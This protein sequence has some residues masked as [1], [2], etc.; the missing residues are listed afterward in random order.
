MGVASTGKWKWTAEK[1]KEEEGEGELCSCLGLIE[2]FNVANK[3]TTKRNVRLIRNARPA[4]QQIQ[5]QSYSWRYRYRYRQSGSY[6]YISGKMAD[7]LARSSHAQMTF[8]VSNKGY[9]HP[10]ASHSLLLLP[11]LWPFPLLAVWLSSS[12]TFSTRAWA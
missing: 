12:S 8:N 4:S 2:W 3:W 1:E 11:P 9:S 6:R 7:H 10:K 5:L